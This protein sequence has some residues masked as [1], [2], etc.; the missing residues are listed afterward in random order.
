MNGK[1]QGN[2]SWARCGLARRVAAMT[3][4]TVIVIGLLL[5]ATAVI[6][7]LDTGNQRALRDPFFTLYLVGIWYFYLSICWIHG[8]MTLGMRAWKIVLQADEGKTGWRHCTTRFVVALISV[9]AVG[10]G[11][12]WSLFDPQRR[13]WHDIASRTGLYLGPVDAQ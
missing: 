4:D 6:S 13:C 1:V 10:A 12:A 8:G 9:A 7:P 5:I 2:S 3:Y 11:F